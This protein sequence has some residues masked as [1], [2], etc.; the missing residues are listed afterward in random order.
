M[1][2]TVGTAPCRTAVAAPD[3]WIPLDVVWGDD[4]PGAR[5][6]LYVTDPAG[7]FV[8]L[9]VD[10]DSGELCELIVINLPRR[11]HRTLESAE[12]EEDRT[13][14]VD[15]ATWSWIAGSDPRE[16]ERPDVDVTGALTYSAEGDRVT[17]WFSDAPVERL[18]R[19]GPVRVGL[20]RTGAIVAVEANLAG[21]PDHGHFSREGSA[22]GA[23][24]RRPES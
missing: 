16:P 10:P 14:V 13:A 5:V 2:A 19:T 8:E 9:K 4:T 20:A 17:L 24:D 12:V 22:V 18:L 7:G 3:P 21:Q 11:V 15:L 23:A 1:I 6:Y